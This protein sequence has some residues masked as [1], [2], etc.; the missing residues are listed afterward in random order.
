MNPTLSHLITRFFT[1][2]LA[3]ERGASKNTIAAYSD[4]LRLFI[5]HL[6]KK[7]GKHP[8]K[9]NLEM[10]E[11]EAV[12]DFLDHLERDR[13][14]SPSTRNQRLAAIKSFLHFAVRE[15]P[16]SILQNERIQAIRAK[17]TD[18]KP[19]PSLSVKQVRAILD[20]IDTTPLIGLRDKAL[21]QLLYN[22]GARVQEIADLHISD[23]HFE[24][25]STL[26]LTG[27]GRKTRTIPLWEET[28]QL[29]QAYLQA[30][31][32]AG[33]QSAHLF[34]NNKREPITRFGIGRR[35]ELHG[36]NAA[37][38]CPELKEMKLTPHVF[39]HT[40][41]LHLIEAGNDITIVKEWLGHAD[42][43]TTSQYI[44]VSVARKREALEKL[45]PPGSGERVVVP[46][47]KAPGIIEFLSSLSGNRK[48]CCDLPVRTAMGDH[49]IACFAT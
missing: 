48:L 43:K 13:K 23:L 27:K 15:D 42:I 34:L 14:N 25:P 49:P 5:N 40:T 39:R 6:C 7:H 28:V 37:E 1:T 32:Y 33:I 30:R 44:E 19:P 26:T 38:K 45:P 41:A 22:T 20:S 18:H 29:I 11:S 9:L 47:W 21:I 36:K 31:E 10:F 46:E 12:L 3:S 4:T 2:Y 8:E 16:E 17:K 35:V 24:S